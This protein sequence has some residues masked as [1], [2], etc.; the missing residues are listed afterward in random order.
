MIIVSNGDICIRTT[1][2]CM[3]IEDIVRFI[4]K[5]NPVSPIQIIG[6]Y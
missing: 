2:I 4:P 6:G 1:H 3:V 5:L